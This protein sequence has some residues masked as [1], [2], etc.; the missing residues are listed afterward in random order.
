MNE[1]QR[2]ALDLLDRII[3]DCNTAPAE[4]EDAAERP[5]ERDDPD[6]PAAPAAAPAAT[7]RTSRELLGLPW[8]EPHPGMAADVWDDWCE[9]WA[10]RPPLH[11]R[12]SMGLA[13]TSY[14]V[15]V[16][17]KNGNRVPKR[18]QNGEIVRT[19]T[20]KIKYATTVIQ[21]W[22]QSGVFAFTTGYTIYDRPADN[23]AEALKSGLRALTVHRGRA[24]QNAELR[25]H[26]YPE[27]LPADP[28]ALELEV[29]N[30]TEYPG[31]PTV[32][33]KGQIIPGRKSKATVDQIRINYPRDP[34]YMYVVI[35]EVVDGKL[36]PVEGFTGTQDEFIR[37]LITG[38]TPQTVPIGDWFELFVTPDFSPPK[39]WRPGHTPRASAI[40]DSKPAK[41]PAKQAADW[42]KLD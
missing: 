11:F 15:P 12:D 9:G 38:E 40:P 1:Q 34:G 10:W 5:A 7:T 16:L 3:A 8:H 27:G 17:D 21:Q 2:L 36:Q 32:V 37:V 41:Q 29:I 26:K 25:I 30:R 35:Q 13:M 42:L 23:W 4:L 19:K 28:Y 31:K 6:E 18:D 24:A 33:R 39:G 20:G 14:I 22:G